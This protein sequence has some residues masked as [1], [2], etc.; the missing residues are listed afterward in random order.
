MNSPRQRHGLSCAVRVTRVILQVVVHKSFIL[1]Q[2]HFSQ[3]L[4]QLL[5][6][7]GRLQHSQISWALHVP[8]SVS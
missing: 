6:A 1:A 7:R 2:D 4:S 8:L 3:C 5:I